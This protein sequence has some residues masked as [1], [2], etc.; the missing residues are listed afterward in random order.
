MRLMAVLLLLAGAARA[1]TER[2]GAFDHYVLALSWSAGWCAVA[3]D[4]RGADQCHPR[5]DHG[6]LLHGLWPQHAGGDWPEFCQSPHAPPG[7]A[8]TRAMADI[9][10][11]AGL[12]WH[13]WRKH[14]SC[15]GLSPQAYFTLSRRAFEAVAQ[16]DVFRRLAAP[17]R[18]P[19]DVVEEAF[20]EANPFLSPEAMT[21]S[22]PGGRVT[23]LRVCLG[24]DLVPRSCAAGMISCTRPSVVMD[25]VR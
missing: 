19:P 1:G 21:V 2:P 12:A 22:C 23:E 17:V 4:A 13:Q 11:S 18:L 25:P 3:G 8:E 15:T 14:G 10:G 6:F 7:R 20:V 16:P 24:R 9:M 5:H